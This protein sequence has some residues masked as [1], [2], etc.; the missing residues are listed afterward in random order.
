MSIF[1]TYEF[2]EK[3]KNQEKASE[4]FEDIVA[5][6]T[7]CNREAYLEDVNCEAAGAIEIFIRFWNKYDDERGIPVEER[8]PIKIYID[9]CGGFLSSAFT[10]I[11]AIEMSKTPVWTINTGD[12]F[13]AGFF[14]FIAGHKRFAY[15]LSSFL[16]HEGST[17]GG[18]S[19]DAHKFRNHADFYS[20]QLKQ[21][22]EHTI[23]YTNI[24]EEEYQ[25]IQKDDYWLTASEALEQGVC[26]EILEAFI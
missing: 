9:S 25:K 19:V 26:D 8:E 6:Y 2:L 10:I 20:K 23:K 24:T 3:Y 11:N 12:A 14:I 18:G 13:S 4:K 21:L 17:G 1:K 15:R 5:A 7:Q 22:K 16:F